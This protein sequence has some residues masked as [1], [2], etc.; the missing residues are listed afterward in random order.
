MSKK[1]IVG[2]LVAAGVLLFTGMNYHIV[3]GSEVSGVKFEKKLSM[4]LSET[5]INLD[6]V[7][8]MP[9]IAARSQY[10]M[11][12]AKLE[13]LQASASQQRNSGCRNIY[14]GMSVEE[15]VPKC[16]RPNDTETTG[17]E[18]DMRWDTG[19]RIKAAN[20]KVTYVT[21]NN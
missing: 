21:G 3:T 19:V 9:M 8:N 10:P 7:M 18:I 15:I 4:S 12:V 6:S 20:G 11:Y 14:I 13:R 16:G 5:F 2:L 1:M 17:T